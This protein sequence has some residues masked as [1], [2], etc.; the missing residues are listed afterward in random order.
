MSTVARPDAVVA[1]PRRPSARLLTTLGALAGLALALYL[2]VASVAA[3]TL[4]TPRRT[5]GRETPAAVGLSYENVRF[6]ARDDG[7]TIAGWYV[8]RQ[9]AR[10][11]LVLVHGKD[12]SRAKWVRDEWRPLVPAL[13][14]RGFAVL[15][16]D[17]RGHGGS[18]DARY[19]FGLNERRD[20]EGAV[21]WLRQ[22]GFAAGQ[23][24]VLGVSMG[25]ASGILAAADDPDIG[26]LVADCSYAEILPVIEQEWRGAS[27]LPD[28]LL[29]GT[30]LVSRLLLGVNLADARPVDLVGRIAPRPLLLIHSTGDTLIPAAHADRLLA[31]APGAQLWKVPGAAHG[32]SFKAQPQEYTRRVLSFFEQSLK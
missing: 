26:A 9:G 21:D 27:G 18:A 17:L 19:S 2:A 11:A 31:A 22:Q 25:A 6:P 16:I 20:V 8:P 15:L 24:G 4:T 10:R 29:P 28:A 7:L 3:L 13:N 12:N 14:G 1:P 23:I 30:L 32:E 5:L